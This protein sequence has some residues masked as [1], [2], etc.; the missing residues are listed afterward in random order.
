MNAMH[1]VFLDFYVNQ[2]VMSGEI[3]AQTC[4]FIRA[5]AAERSGDRGFVHIR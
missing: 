3:Q 1:F 4:T 5:Y 2:K